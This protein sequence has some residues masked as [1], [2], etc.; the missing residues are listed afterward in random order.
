[1]ND[2][3]SVIIPV[4][5]VKPYLSRC[6]DSVLNQTYT[7]LDIILIDDGSDDGSEELCD[8]YFKKYPD[9]ITLVHQ[10]NKGL[11]PARNEGLKR[12]RG[13]YISMID[14]DDWISL[15]MYEKLYNFSETYGYQIS[16]CDYFYIDTA[17]STV[18]K[19]KSIPS[20]IPKQITKEEAL[21][22]NLFCLVQTKFFRAD[23]IKNKSFPNLVFED[24]P[25][26]VD[27][28]CEDHKMGYLPEPLYYY[29]KKQGTLSSVLSCRMLDT[30]DSED[31]A[32]NK[33][34]GLDREIC[35]YMFAK[36]FVQNIT[37]DRKV[38]TADLVEHI[39]K[40][41]E[42]LKN[43]KYLLGDQIK[44]TIF[45]YLEEDTIPLNIFISQFGGKK[46]DIVYQT[47]LN[48]WKDKTRNANLVFLSEE[49]CDLLSAPECVRN[50]YNTG[51]YL[52]VGDYFKCLFIYKEGGIA[53][54]ESLYF[55][56]PIGQMR[57]GTSFFSFKSEYE[58]SNCIYGSCSGTKLFDLILQTYLNND[59]SLLNVR[60]LNVL[61]NVYGLKANGNAQKLKDNIHVYRLDYLIYD[62]QTGNNISKLMN[63][64]SVELID[65]EYEVVSKEALSFFNKERNRFYKEREQARKETMSV[66]KTIDY[67]RVL[68]LEKDLNVAYNKISQ[69]ENSK[70]WR[71]TAPFR[72]LLSTFKR[73]K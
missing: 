36:R 67:K 57:I 37:S 7:N 54:D 59:T 8:E 10:K 64:S 5:N 47:C 58:L 42:E 34:N 60:A 27:T 26:L 31:M 71:F 15:D 46:E 72:R 29:E 1:M 51:D 55:N 30:I 22:N 41:K 53:I 21:L 9:R 33:L 19:T 35:L 70:S 43:N 25:V 73:Y 50:A 14:S 32:I 4:Y 20:D 61:S 68:Q 63:S 52:F 11:G 40:Y 62:L 13:K 18:T 56:K 16:I 45:K 23:V 24:M 6:L 3:I 28:F 12:A 17:K 44:D 38:F 69:M 2:L 66:Q 48:S 65:S 49:N 39:K